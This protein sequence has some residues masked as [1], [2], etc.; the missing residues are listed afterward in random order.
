MSR[1]SALRRG[2]ELVS[3]LLHKELQV[4]YRGSLLG[5]VWSV[6]HPL[7][8]GLI[9]WLVFGKIMR[10]PVVE[11]PLFLLS[12]L[13]SW[14]WIVSSLGNA[15]AIFLANSAIIRK[16]AFPRGVLPFSQVLMEGVHF[17]CALPVLAGFLMWYG[18]RPA[19][20]WLWAVPA[21]FLLQLFLLTGIACLL[22]SLTPFLR[23]LER[24]VQLGIMMLMYATP[25]IWSQEMLPTRWQWLLSLNPMAPLVVSWRDLLLHNQ[26][27]LPLFPL[28][29]QTALLSL[30]IGWQVLRRLAPRLAEVL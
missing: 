28:M 15:P 23:D 4:R 14:Q 26:V 20:C 3:V 24:F 12:G 6:A 10:V 17:L 30:F 9:Y 7:T 21:L 29:I 2:Y 1:P 13:F 22:A 11:Y 8:F 16:T 5:Y 19:A 25:V 18:H 27:A